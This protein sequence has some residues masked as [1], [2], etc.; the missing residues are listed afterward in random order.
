MCGDGPARQFL[1]AA[2]GARC[3]TLWGAGLWT[4]GVYLDLWDK[5]LNLW[6]LIFDLGARFWT[7]GCPILGRWMGS[8]S[9][10]WGADL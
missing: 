10:P 1:R 7:L 9:G 8:Y 5:N 4:L 2:P 3:W 6:G